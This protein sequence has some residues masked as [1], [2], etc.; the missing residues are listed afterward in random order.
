[1]CEE[2]SEIIKAIIRVMQEAQSVGKNLD[3]G[4]GNSSYKGVADKDVKELL[5]PLLVKNG[6]AVLPADITPTVRIERYDTTSEAMPA[7][8]AGV[9]SPAGAWTKSQA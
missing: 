5:Q 7:H 2:K 6:L 3:V 9:E 1:M 4:T 8:N